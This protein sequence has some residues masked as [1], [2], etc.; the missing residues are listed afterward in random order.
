[1]KIKEIKILNALSKSKLP[2]CDYV[3]NPYVG[4]TH[5][6]AYCYARYMKFFSGHKENWGEFLDIK[7]NIAW[8]LENQ[9]KR[10]A[11]TSFY[12][13]GKVFMSSVTDPYQPIEKKYKLTRKCL[14]LLAYYDWPTSVL[15]KSDLVTRD[16]KIFKKFKKIEVGLSIGTLNSEN[17]KLFEPGS[18]LIADRVKALEELSKNGIKTYLFIAPV[19]PYLTDLEKMF[20]FFSKRVE[21]INVETLNTKTVNWNGVREV[22]GNNF[23]ELLPKYEKIYFSEERENYLRDLEHKVMKLGKTYNVKTKTYTHD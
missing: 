4:C 20:E 19:F 18:S 14:E 11:R 10:V 12:S 9:L 13:K 1:M 16:I 8:A 15:T 23:P 21:K 7:S 22:L 5:K 2:D 17:S 3:I 6:C